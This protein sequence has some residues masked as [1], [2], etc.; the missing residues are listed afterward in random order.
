MAEYAL[1]VKQPWTDLVMVRTDD[2]GCLKPVENRCWPVPS[3]LPQR[4]EC[5]TCG[6]RFEERD[7]W[8][9][10][11][12]GPLADAGPFPFRLWIHAGQQVVNP[13]DAGEAWQALM[14]HLE[15][16]PNAMLAYVHGRLGVLLGSVTVT[17]CH[18][19]DECYPT[20]HWVDGCTCAGPFGMGIGM[21]HEPGCGLEPW[22]SPWSEPNA[23]HW[24]LTDPQPLATPIPVRGRQKLW[25]L[26]D[27]IAV[28]AAHA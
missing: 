15:L 11:N 27:D 18:H 28:E 26:P 8:N 2:G 24:T 1:T 16:R 10:E 9:D 5:E 7:H 14:D 12:C 13:L 25:T 21:Q 20:G 4:W 17:G 19:S 3:T 6:D 23:W 22:C